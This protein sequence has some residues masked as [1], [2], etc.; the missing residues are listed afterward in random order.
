MFYAVRACCYTAARVR[1][2][3]SA[4]RSCVCVCWL[5]NYSR[6]AQRISK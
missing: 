3:V 6:A 4:P 5:M 1:V 2:R